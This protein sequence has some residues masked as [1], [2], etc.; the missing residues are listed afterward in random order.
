[1]PPRGAAG[2][3]GPPGRRESVGAAGGG[4]GDRTGGPGRPW[5]DRGRRRPARGRGAGLRA[6]RGAVSRTGRRLL[7]PG[8]LIPRPWQDRRC[9]AGRVT[10]HAVWSAVAAA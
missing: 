5:T 2:G 10:A 8:A 6:R 1:A 3:G 7:R 4:G 9:G